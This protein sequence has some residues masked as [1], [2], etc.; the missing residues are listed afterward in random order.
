MAA[1]PAAG[2]PAAGAA[3]A[4]AIA[5]SAG[6]SS[7]G[8]RPHGLHAPLVRLPPLPL[9]PAVSRVL[10]GG[11]CDRWGPRAAAATIQLLT[12][13]ASFGQRGNSA[14]A[15]QCQCNVALWPVPSSLPLNAPVHRLL[16][17]S[18]ALCLR[19]LCRPRL[20]GAGMAV[21]GDGTGYI[22]A[23]LFIGFSPASFVPVLVLG[24]VQCQ[25]P[26]ALPIPYGCVLWNEA[27]GRLL[28][29]QEGSR[30][31]WPGAPPAYPC[32]DT[33]PPPHPAGL[34]ALPTRWPRAGAT[35]RGVSCSWSCLSC[36]RWEGR[37]GAAG[38]GCCA[39][40][41][42]LTRSHSSLL[43]PQHGP[44]RSGAPGTPHTACT[45]CPALPCPCPPP[46]PLPQ[47]LS[48]SQPDFVAWR[49]C[50]L[51]VGWMQVLVGIAVGDPQ[52]KV[53]LPS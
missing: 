4:C 45:P 49:C 39:A 14:P 8:N 12:A 3:A 30:A 34:W 38:G 37:Q 7:Q 2:A 33:P 18:G 51:I 27:A 15:R 13:S 52:H 9:R 24:D 32:W 53:S 25:V 5:P 40:R 10:T 36:W 35:R 16:H 20:P 26:V 19:P 17:A 21:V 6:A 28:P 22:T 29:E 42:G 31:A 23:R 43:Q 48:R 1:W 41:P 47:A 44:V 46:C 11:V 50:Y